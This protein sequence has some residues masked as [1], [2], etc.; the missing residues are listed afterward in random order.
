MADD[1][2]LDNEL[3]TFL[4]EVAAGHRRFEE[5][6]ENYDPLALSRTASLRLG[7]P[8]PPD[9]KDPAFP[10]WNAL[11]SSRSHPGAQVPPFA[12]IDTPTTGYNRLGLK[13][14]METS[15]N[16]SGAVIS[17]PY[18]RRPFD[19]LIA[20]WEVPD[21]RKPSGKSAKAYACSTWIGFDGHRRVSRSLPQLGTVQQITLDEAGKETSIVKAWWQWWWKYTDG[22]HEYDPARFAVSVGD[23]IIASLFIIPRIGVLFNMTNVNTGGRIDS[24]LVAAPRPELEPRGLDA[25]CVLERPKPFNDPTT[26]F[27]VPNFDPTAF[28]CYAFLSG[29]TT[30]RDMRGG[31]VLRM[32]HLGWGGQMETIAAPIREG[33]RHFVTVRYCGV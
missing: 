8:P 20:A 6:G 13:G 15:R 3:L 16:W 33:D 30:S 24:V 4:A 21:F 11:A 5:P 25:E 19:F 23:K 27:V 18:R 17:S 9:R 29:A 32:V 26:N 31:R 12:T 2:L 28:Q 1:S 7:L 14:H 10:L 22:P